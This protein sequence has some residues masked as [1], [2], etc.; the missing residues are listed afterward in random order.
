MSIIYI[1]LGLLLLVLG[2]NWL[3]KAAVGLSLK[4]NI[5]KVVIGMTVVS[6]A[7]SAPELIVSIKSALSGATGLAVGN[8]IGSNIANLGLVLG[9]TIILSTIEVEKSFYKTDWPVMMLASGLLYFFIAFDYTIQRYEGIILFT[10]LIAFLVYLLRFQKNTVVVDEISE[11]EEEMPLYKIILFLVIGGFCLWLGSEW[12]IE[13]ATSLAK[14]MGVSDAIIGVT[15]VSVGTSVPE[16]AASII[17]VLKKEKAISLGNLIGSNVFNILAVLGITA[18]ITPIQ[19]END[20]L[21]LVNSDIYWMLAISFIVLPFAFFPKK[22]RLN[23]VHGILLLVAYTV[24]VY[25]KLS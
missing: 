12:L 8:V 10:M 22:L 14:N 2:G 15:V 7:T 5:S 25:L 20:A 17:A 23:W 24:F 13:G 18:I 6:F 1:V 19:L 4:L 3:L 9:I 21:S 16:L 11:E